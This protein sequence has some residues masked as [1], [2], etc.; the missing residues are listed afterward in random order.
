MSGPRTEEASDLYRDIDT[1]S[2]VD[3]LSLIAA[4]QR[5][6]IDAVANAVPELA[7][8][9]EAIASG[10]R[11]GGRLVYA[12]AGSSGLLA[13]V[14][15]LELPGTYGIDPEQIVVL[16][17]GGREAMFDIPSKAEDDGD[18]AAQEVAALGL[19]SADCLV[20]ISAS[21]STPYVV[22]ALRCARHAG[23]LTV[24]IAS[25]PETPLLQNADHPV[26]LATPP[27]VI[28]GSTRMNAGTAQKCALNMLS[29]LIAIRLGH[30]FRGLMVNMQADNE[31]LRR[32]AV[33]VVA[34]AADV[35][36]AAARE[37]L[38]RAHGSV[39]PAILLAA[40]AK[41]LEKAEA[42]LKSRGGDVR[43]ALAALAA[44]DSKADPTAVTNHR[45]T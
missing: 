1:L 7:G 15:A 20:G 11:R 26:L 38:K 34:G 5:E 23:A 4:T 28:A 13:Q 14:D 37:A 33:A 10:M 43:D 40:G 19:T 35:D 24:G 39:K 44:D 18:M 12:G 45:R 36:A 27:E 21:G 30:T 9:A 2:G 17:A 3:V 31:K 6:A 8:A 29:T 22:S 32:R 16:L 41:S 25:N 42:F